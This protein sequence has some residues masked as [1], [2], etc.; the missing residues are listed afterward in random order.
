M[1]SAVYRRALKNELIDFVPDSQGSLSLPTFRGLAVTVDDALE[2]SEGNFTSILFG[3]NAVG[4][5]MAEP[6]VADG[7]EIESLPSAGNGGGQQVLHSRMNL[8]MHPAG[9]SWQETAVVGESPTIAEL[10]DATNW[11]RVIER[12]AVPI[13]FLVSKVA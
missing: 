2:A 3:S 1:H 10:E 12:K 13:S 4:Y 5:G 11:S 7:T 6:T 9:F 8:A